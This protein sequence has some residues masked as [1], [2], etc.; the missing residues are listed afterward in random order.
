MELDKNSPFV[1]F[2]CFFLTRNRIG[3]A[4]AHSR[5]K[6][7]SPTKV[8]DVRQLLEE[9]RLSQNRQLPPVSPSRKTGGLFKCV[10]IIVSNDAK[11][12]KS[13]T[14]VSRCAAAAGE[15]T[16]LSREAALAFTFPHQWNSSSQRSKQRCASQTGRGHSGQ[17]RSLLHLSSR[18][19]DKYGPL[20]HPHLCP[21]W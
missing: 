4:V 16:L 13:F 1:L 14:S 5:P 2:C 9:K 8:M 17:Q 12:T 11:H 19:K 3:G 10:S 21:R 18:Q 7:V 6:S 15:T 20:L